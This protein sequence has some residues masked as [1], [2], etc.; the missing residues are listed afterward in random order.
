MPSERAVIRSRTRG[1]ARGIGYDQRPQEHRERIVGGEPRSLLSF[2]GQT[3][4][5]TVSSSND[6]RECDGI[7]TPELGPQSC[8]GDS[9]SLSSSQDAASRPKAASSEVSVSLTCSASAR[10]SAAHVA[11]GGAS[12]RGTE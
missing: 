7:L 11:G 5:G 2:G 6:N 10:K 9:P 12:T 3:V 1:Q 4:S 8:V